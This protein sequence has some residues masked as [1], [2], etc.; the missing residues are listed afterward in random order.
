MEKDSIHEYR[1]SFT[2]NHGQS[3]FIASIEESID[4]S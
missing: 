3:H 4:G 2:D 1:T